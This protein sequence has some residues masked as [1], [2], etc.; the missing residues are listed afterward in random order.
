M[1]NMNKI[2]NSILTV[3]VSITFF[4]F[5]T[6]TLVQA[7]PIQNVIGGTG[8]AVE[9]DGTATVSILESYRLPQGCTIDQIAKWDSIK[10][11]CA[12]DGLT[13][14]LETSGAWN[15]FGLSLI[16]TDNGSAAHFS[17]NNPNSSANALQGYTNGEGSAIRAY[18]EGKGYAFSADSTGENATLAIMNSG[19]G[20]AGV[21]ESMNTVNSNP[22]LQI[23][24]GHAGDAFQSAMFGFGSAGTFWID[25]PANA[26]PGISLSTNG[27]GNAID[28]FTTGSGRAI[29]AGANNSSPAL[30]AM[31]EGLG[32]A[33][34]FEVTNVDN[35]EAALLVKAGNKG[36]AFHA[37]M[38]GL[39]T[40]GYFSI[41][42]P[43]N[44]STVL[45]LS[46]N[47]SGNVIDATGGAGWVANF[48]TLTGNGLN[49]SVPSG[50]PGLT[51]V[52]GTKGSVVTTSEK[53]RM[54]YTEESTEVWFTDYGFGQLTDGVATVTIDPLYAQTVN[55]SVPYHIFVQ[56]YGNTGLY[57]T[58]RT[59]TGF[60]VHASDGTSNAEFS[61]RIVAKRLG[62][63]GIRLEEAG[64]AEWDTNL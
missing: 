47:G 33:A 39:G 12:D 1:I 20:M 25:N 63:E 62:F 36:S 22:A 42:N 57:V 53:P 11:I 55:L 34:A 61:Y 38:G 5:F 16:N 60:E 21:F 41:N 10:W 35:E 19:T 30:V 46:T 44:N 4:L 48:T 18:S 31:N 17:I 32:Q 43:L 23:K 28:V 3:F 29:S 27:S 26:S 15:D 40:A 50:N 51:V 52:G 37:N 2:I 64:W 56:S 13:L 6:S 45:N 14:P 8:I 49:I 58:N 54:L 24:A 9:G 59:G 7:K